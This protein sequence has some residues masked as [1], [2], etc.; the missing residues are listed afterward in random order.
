MF[1][2]TAFPYLYQNKQK[3]R[4]QNK[5]DK[6]VCF[7]TSTERWTPFVYSNCA[8]FKNRNIIKKPKF[9]CLTIL[10]CLTTFKVYLVDY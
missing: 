1:V 5:M 8:I 10:D 6:E 2:Y 9:Y 3:L 7:K 4:T